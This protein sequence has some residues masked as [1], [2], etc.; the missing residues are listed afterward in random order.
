[1]RGSRDDTAA[2]AARETL[3]KAGIERG[4]EIDLHTRLSRRSPLGDHLRVVEMTMATVVVQ[5][6]EGSL[7]I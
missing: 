4:V 1:M 6:K 5:D 2:V 7:Q 3:K